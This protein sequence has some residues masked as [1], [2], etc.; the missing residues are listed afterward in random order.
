MAAKTNLLSAT[1]CKNATS[2]G[3]AIRKLHDGGGLYLWVYTDG[4]KFWRLRYRLGG[5]EKSL[6][7]G[8]YPQVSLKDARAK[9]DEQHKVLDADLDPSAERKANALRTKLANVNSFEAVALEWYNKQLHTWVEHHASDV[10]RRLESNIFPTIGKRPIDQISALE[11][12][13]T[14]RKIE[15]RG[16]YDLAHRVLQVCGQVFRYGIATG[17]CARNLSAD[18]RG[19]LTPHVK[20]HQSAVRPEELP[21]LLRAIAK[22]DETGDKQT[23]LALQLLAQTFVRTN[24]LIGAEWKEFDFENGL[25]I[26]PAERMKMK[27]EHVVPLAPQALSKLAEL[28]ELSSGSRFVFPGRN[29][30][31]PISNNTMLFA[32]YRLGYKGKMTGHGFRAVASTI[33]N[34]SGFK[35]DVIERQLA[36]C[37]RNEV[38]A[39]YNRAEYLPERR[40]MMQQWAD[41]LDSIEAGAKV[42]PFKTGT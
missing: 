11:L 33:L 34:E 15:A 38:R 1:E 8:S 20:Q 29:R 30:D 27:S 28:K 26:I 31:K 24:E 9:R 19:A 42:I 22:Y 40:I 13:E 12:L 18:L 5:K 35:P 10:K 17:R 39:A 7:F 36:H 16:S 3:K 37:E 21:D 4:G 32:L 25:W 41:Y 6:S 23:R 14:I 2:E